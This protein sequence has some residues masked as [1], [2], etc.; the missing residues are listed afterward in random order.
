MPPTFYS[1]I[2]KLALRDLQSLIRLVVAAIITAATELVIEWN[3]IQ[4]VN[5]V[6]SAGQTIP[7]VIGI[8]QVAQIIYAAY[9]YEPAGFSSI[10]SVSTPE[11]AA[12]DDFPEA[13]SS[14]S[15][16]AGSW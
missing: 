11:T 12:T 2:R 7:M 16:D 8:G 6:S 15:S 14:E 13:G 1:K 4:D 5:E 3:G 9:K 10:W